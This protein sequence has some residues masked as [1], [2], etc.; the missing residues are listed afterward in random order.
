MLCIALPNGTNAPFQLAHVTFYV[1]SHRAVASSATAHD[2]DCNTFVT[3]T[4]I[5]HKNSVRGEV[6]GLGLSG[7]PFVCPVRCTVHH[8][9]HFLE[10]NA[11]PNTPLCTYY[12]DNKAHYVTNDDISTTLKSSIQMPSTA[13][14]FAATN[15]SASSLCA[16]SVMS[17]LYAH[18]GSDPIHLIGHG[19]SNEMLRYFTVQARPTIM[20]DFSALMLQGSQY[21]LLSN[22]TVLIA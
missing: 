1:G 12:S 5:T 8:V 15:V 11:P 22:A 18:T 7:N 13:L 17:L 10:H 6:I 2:L 21:T 16:G 9:Q 4:F 14:R 3:L 20:R 19:H